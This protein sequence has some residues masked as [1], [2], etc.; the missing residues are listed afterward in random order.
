MPH[1]TTNDLPQATE[2]TPDSSSEL[3]PQLNPIQRRIASGMGIF[4]AV[5]TDHTCGEACWEAREDTCRCC[6]GGENHGCMRSPDGIRPT[7]TAKIDGLRYV[8]KAT[9]VSGHRSSDHVLLVARSAVYDEAQ[10]LNEAHGGQT[11]WRSWDTNV[12]RAPAR[13]R[14]AGKDQLARWPELASY[15]ASIEQIKAAGRYCVGELMDASPILLW[16]REDLSEI[17]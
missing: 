12:K 10:R 4:A 13:I 11:H 17:Q 3:S 2:N 5:F 9:A 6:C 1:F 14:N 7:R 15:R 8:L 16:V